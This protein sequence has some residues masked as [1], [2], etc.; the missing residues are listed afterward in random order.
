MVDLLSPI[1]QRS[2]SPPSHATRS[3]RKVFKPSTLAAVQLMRVQYSWLGGAWHEHWQVTGGA[4]CLLRAPIL[5]THM[6]PHET[7][8]DGFSSASTEEFISPCQQWQDNA[9]IIA[10]PTHYY[11]W[12]LCDCFN[13]LSCATLQSLSNNRP[14]IITQIITINVE[15]EY[16]YLL[17]QCV[18]VVQEDL[19]FCSSAVY[20]SGNNHVS[21]MDSGEHCP[22]AVSLT[23]GFPSSPRE[24][25]SSCHN[26]TRGLF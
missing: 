1:P 20:H 16:V 26:Y 13:S 5:H 4:Q 10:P 14:Q 3:P 24:G 22:H 15:H 7:V 23:V 25:K 2:A 12:L 11:Y 18:L 6:H 17:Q 21:C 19:V 9:K 8:K